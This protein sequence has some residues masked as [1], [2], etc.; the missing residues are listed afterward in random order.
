MPG[1]ILD[2]SR[3][4]S[5]RDKRDPIGVIV[6]IVPFNFPMMVP[7]W[8]TPIAIACGNAVILKPSEKVPM[9]MTF[10]A[11]LFKEA[12]VPDGIFQTVNG[13]RN[14]CEALIDHLEHEIQAP[15]ATP[16]RITELV[17]AMPSSTTQGNHTIANH[18]IA[19]LDEIAAA[20]NG[21]VP[22]HG[23]MFAQWMHHVYPRECPYPHLS[24]TTTA[25]R[26][27]EFQKQTGLNP[28]ASKADMQQCIA[29]AT[30]V[31]G[32]SEVSWST[33]DE[34]YVERTEPP[35]KGNNAVSSIARF[36]A[37]F[38][39]ALSMV[40]F[41]LGLGRTIRS[42]MDDQTFSKLYV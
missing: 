18:L 20:N 4:V 31:E 13:T 15:A 17:A 14:T 3:G 7:F 10:V 19:R 24:G 9:T 37:L 33:E 34:F 2:V 21:M 8:T 30:G 1:K 5:C 42:D 38:F 12:G 22:L 27:D 6:S 41:L 23:R 35:A 32:S 36:L 29:D 26:T 40:Y 39:L 28:T 16:S 25:L 11:S